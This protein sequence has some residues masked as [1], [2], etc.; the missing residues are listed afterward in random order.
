[1]IFMPDTDITLEIPKAMSGEQRKMTKVRKGMG[2]AKYSTLITT[3][4][5]QMCKELDIKAGDS[6]M[7]S[8]SARNRV[9]AVFRVDTML[10]E[11]TALMYDLLDKL[12]TSNLPEK[13]K[14]A[15]KAAKEAMKEMG[16]VGKLS[17]GERRKD[18][19]KILKEHRER[20]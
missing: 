1:M 11:H 4:P 9:M 19:K 2:V 15:I 6:L 18:V 3:I 10:T 14:E 20:K 16:P 7:W 13:D 5:A 8:M 17:E 12:Q